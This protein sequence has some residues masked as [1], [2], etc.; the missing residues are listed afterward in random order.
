MRAE[1]V[2]KAYINFAQRHRPSVPVRDAHDI[3][4]TSGRFGVNGVRDV[5]DAR[6]VRD[7]RRRGPRR[8]RT[9]QAEARARA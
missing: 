1:I 5:R 7:V 8:H 2:A 4:R 9:P 3:R 6:D